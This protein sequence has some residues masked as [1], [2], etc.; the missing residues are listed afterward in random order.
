MQEL[1]NHDI[2][3]DASYDG[4][5]PR[6]SERASAALVAD[7]A[8]VT[9]LLEY[10]ADPERFVL[11]HVGLTRISGR[12]YPVFPTWN[13]LKIELASDGQ[14]S[15]DAAQREAL[16]QRWRAWRTTASKPWRDQ[17]SQ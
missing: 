8:T 5:V 2:E 4:F 6:I 17:G 11:A 15:I 14:V 10:L 3:W 12:P 16:I 7:E 1:S 9:T 13:G